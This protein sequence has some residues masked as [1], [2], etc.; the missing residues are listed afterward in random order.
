MRWL[1]ARMFAAAGSL[2]GESA[3]QHSFAHGATWAAVLTF[4]ALASSAGDSPAARAVHT[5]PELD[6]L[7]VIEHPAPPGSPSTGALAVHLTGNAGYNMTDQLLAEEL[8]AHGVPTVVLSSLRY[9]W[10]RRTP[11][12]AAGDLERILRYG[13]RTWDKE[14]IALT[15]Y[16]MGADVLPFLLNRLPADLQARVQ[17]VALIS[18][19]SEIDFDVHLSDLVRDSA[20]P[21]SLP[22]QPELDRM[23]CQQVLC[24]CG[25][26]EARCLCSHL[27]PG[28]AQVI[29]LSGGHRMGIHAT[30]IADSV[31]AA[32]R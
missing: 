32:L 2:R 14:E 4:A 3:V 31:L 28:R 30:A 11:D 5:S 13:L 21:T 22:T 19:G 27:P 10:H 7:P 20:R 25:R 29:T 15:G 24:F 26:E 6:G 23:T 8:A 17:V 18:P 12:E 16:S 1:A 9:F